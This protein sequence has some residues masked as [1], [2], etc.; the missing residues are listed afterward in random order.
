[1][2]AHLLEV[3]V[4]FFFIVRIFLITAALEIAK[5]NKFHLLAAVSRVQGNEKVK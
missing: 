5:E 4:R 3:S 2:F 1:M